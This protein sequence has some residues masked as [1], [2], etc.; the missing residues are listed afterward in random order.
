MNFGK[1][2]HPLTKEELYHTGVDLVAQQGT[3]VMAVADGTVIYANFDKE[4]GNL[5]KIEHKDNSISTY[6]HGS[7]ILVKEG[8][9]IIKGQT[10]MKVG[11]TGMATGPHLHFEIINSKGEY[12][13]IN[14]MF[15]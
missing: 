3:P 7:E 10:I 8:Q 5:I 9:K 6:A 12:V 4:Y 13:D 1:K 15:E 11:S 14:N 2:I